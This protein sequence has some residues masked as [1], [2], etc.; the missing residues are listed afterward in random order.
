MNGC[1]VS[2]FFANNQKKKNENMKENL[3]ALATCET[4]ASQPG[5]DSATDS[6]AAQDPTRRAASAVDSGKPMLCFPSIFKR[7]SGGRGT[8]RGTG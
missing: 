3:L 2:P 4:Q 1:K 7:A 8:R 6:V 5:I